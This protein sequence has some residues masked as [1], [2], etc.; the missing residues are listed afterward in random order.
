MTMTAAA[1][2]ARETDLLS[3]VLASV[4][5]EQHGREFADRVAWIHRTAAELR[6]GDEGAREALMDCLV[7][8]SNCPM[9]VLAPCNAY[10]CTPMKVTIYDPA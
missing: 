3:G 1:P 5:T 2:V 4:L 6:G 7:G 8:L 10:N 9:D